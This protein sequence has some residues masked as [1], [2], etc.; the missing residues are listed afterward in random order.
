MPLSAL[1]MSASLDLVLRLSPVS[2]VGS[3]SGLES[4]AKATKS[5]PICSG[6]TGPTYRLNLFHRKQPNILLQD[7]PLLLFLLLSPVTTPPQQLG[8]ELEPELE[9]EVD[10]LLML[11]IAF[12]KK[13]RSLDLGGNK[14]KGKET[15]WSLRKRGLKS[16]GRPRTSAQNP[17]HLSSW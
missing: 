7:L 11:S 4:T 13:H 12:R 8:L 1:Y 9:R 10:F 6:S 5:T 14:A 3:T 2:C 17:S 16:T 15:D